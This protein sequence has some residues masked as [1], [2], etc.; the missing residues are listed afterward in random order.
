MLIAICCYAATTAVASISSLCYSRRLQSQTAYSRFF[1]MR[2]TVLLYVC[3]LHSHSHSHSH[4][5]ILHCL[6]L[7]Y[8]LA[9]SL[10]QCVL[11]L[12]AIPIARTLLL[13]LPLLLLCY[14]AV[15]FPIACCFARSTSIDF[16][17]RRAL[18]YATLY[19]ILCL[20]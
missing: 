7:V 9:H 18:F 5:Q 12:L 17:Q 13:L 1:S 16:C 15:A 20:T 19:C 4:T 10:T 6:S 2:Y 14:W 8:T 3:S 11:L